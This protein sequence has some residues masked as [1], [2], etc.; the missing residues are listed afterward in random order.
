MIA[1]KGF[2]QNFTCTMGRGTYR[3]EVGKTY[4]EDAAECAHRG[5][6]CVEEP[7]EVLRW[8]GNGRYC[9]VDATGDVHEDG[10]NKLCCTEITLLKEITLEE[11]G[12]LE[13][14]WVIRHP[15]CECSEQV[16]KNIGQAVQNGIV[17]VRG[18]NPMAAGK[19]GATLFLL[20]EGKGTKKIVSAGA[21]RVDGCEYLP[22]VYYNAE[23][24]QVQVK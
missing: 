9:I 7:I 3:Y 22:D 13:C 10:S 6:H 1:Y 14:E 24:R 23:G 11:L 4:R 17:V 5:F 8:Y 2:N 18:K 21:Y 19:E 20:R 12:I 15:E 16:K